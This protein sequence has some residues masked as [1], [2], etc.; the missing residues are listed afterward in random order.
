[1][2]SLPL[3][4][5]LESV[6]ARPGMFFVAPSFEQ[7]AA[8][9]TGAACVSSAEFLPGFASWYASKLNWGASM[10]VPAHVLYEALGEGWS[11]TSSRSTEVDLVLTELLYERLFEYMD[12]A[13]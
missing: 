13:A 12:R 8:L 4:A 5:F 7:H 3:R 1:M 11:G 10:A 2:T 6:Y 9:L